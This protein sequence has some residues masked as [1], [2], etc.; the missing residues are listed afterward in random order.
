MD[1]RSPAQTLERGRGEV[2]VSGRHVYGNLYGCNP[3][4]LADE[5]KL[6]SIVKEAAVVANAVLISLTYF[7][8]PGGHG[9]S[10]VGI[11][12]ESHISIH[13]W[14]EYRY[15]TVDVYTCGTHTDPY[16]AFEYIAKSLEAEKVEVFVT[17]R[18]LTR[19]NII[20]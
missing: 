12:Q 11:V 16:A 5:V 18:S 8:F 20:P 17:D 2:V 10:V 13:T 14:P 1:L 9:V 15:A 3:E 6:T 19:A 7:K 4:I